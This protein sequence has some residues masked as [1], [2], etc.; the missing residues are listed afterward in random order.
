MRNIRTSLLIGLLLTSTSIFAA[1]L[2]KKPLNVNFNTLIDQSA[3]EK[4][5]LERSL[6][7][8]FKAPA[9]A[10]NIEKQKVMDFVDMEIGVGEAPKMVDRRFN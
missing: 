1:D 5:H 8:N 4:E 10:S 9:T 7:P 3:V 6:K 2:K